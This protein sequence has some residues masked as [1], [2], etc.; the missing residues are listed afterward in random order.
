MPTQYY[1]KGNGSPEVRAKAKSREADKI[2]RRY[3]KNLTLSRK[4]LPGERDH[5]IDIVVVLR[6]AGYEKQQIARILNVGLSQIAELLNDP[7]VS[8]KLVMLRAALPAAALDLL[9]D[10]MIEAVQTLVDIMR[11]AEDDK[12]VL[13]A[14]GEIL[15]RAGLGKATKSERLQV[16]ENRTVFTDDGIIEQLRKAS[17]EVQEQAAQVIEQ[18]ENLLTTASEPKEAEIPE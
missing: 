18:L 9:Q 14:A 3:K 1:R 16:N 10:Y 12:I 8:E 11:S 6:I 2:R 15:D 13:Q 7:A 5:V 17:P 4:F